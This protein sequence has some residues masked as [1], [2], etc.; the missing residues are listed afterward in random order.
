[1]LNM[2]PGNSRRWQR[3]ESNEYLKIKD[4][5]AFFLLHTAVKSEMEIDSY[6]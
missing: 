2:N 4:I 1:M 3:Q 6:F 5:F